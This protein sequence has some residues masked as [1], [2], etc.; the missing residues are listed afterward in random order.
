[1]ADIG[2]FKK[3]L[4]ALLLS[5]GYEDLSKMVITHQT[6]KLHHTLVVELVEDVIQQQNGLVTNL[7]VVVF[8]LRQTDGNHERFL[9]ALR[10]KLL[11][12]MPVKEKLQ[13]VL[14][15]AY[16]GVTRIGILLNILFQ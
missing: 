12:R 7:L 10:A 5:V 11:Q 1:M 4:N 15:N 16:V 6:H 13:V 9:L 8:K 2:V 14:V 3:T